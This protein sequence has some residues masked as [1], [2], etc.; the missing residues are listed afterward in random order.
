MKTPRSKSAAD[1]ESFER[2][3]QM[4]LNG[5]R[6]WEQKVRRGK[7]A[8]VFWV[9]CLLIGIV[10]GIAVGVGASDTKA[11]APAVFGVV[12]DE[13]GTAIGLGTV[14]VFS[15]EH[16]LVNSEQIGTDGLYLASCSEG[17]WL[18][19]YEVSGFQPELR[20]VSMSSQDVHRLDVVLKRAT[21]MIAGV[22]VDSVGIPVQD[23]HV[24]LFSQNHGA[25]VASTETGN[26]GRFRLDVAPGQYSISVWSDLYAFEPKPITLLAGEQAEVTLIGMPAQVRVFGT[27]VTEDDAV[28]RD[29]KVSVYTSDGR[30]VG[31]TRSDSDGRYATHLP[32]GVWEIKVWKDGWTHV[33]S[34]ITIKPGAVDVRHSVTL[35][36]AD[37]SISGVVV[38]SAGKPIPNAWVEVTDMETGQWAATAQT[39]ESGRFRLEIASGDWS[40]SLIA[41]G[42]KRARTRV[43][44]ERPLPSPVAELG[45]NASPAD[46]QTQAGNAEGLIVIVM[47]PDNPGLV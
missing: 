13:E 33:G 41:E 45:M 23:A 47:Q 32:P 12:N 16:R 38:S 14:Y 18:L 5:R 4:V 44:A 31:S 42:Y 40:L 10:I 22:V 7:L 8:L 35:R 46:L 11:I 15:D 34:R 3:R 20:S 21:S 2:S 27:V 6:K 25:S 24:V 29:A 19:R 28:V 39:D 26:D 37:A 9:A 17:V 1:S 30:F 43:S 36:R